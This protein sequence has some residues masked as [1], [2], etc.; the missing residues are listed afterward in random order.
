MT[1]NSNYLSNSAQPISSS[2]K[3]KIFKLSPAYIFIAPAVIYI[4]ALV[5]F[6]TLRVAILSVMETVR[7]TG[8]THFVGLKNFQKVLS[9][10]VFQKS[11]VQTAQWVIFTA[12]GHF[13]LGFILA[14]AM[15][16]KLI[17]RTITSTCRAL[18]LLPWALTSVVVAI[19][20]QL[21]A[22]PMISPIAKVLKIL[23]STTDFVPLAYPNTAMW[24]LIAVQI[25]QFTP[26]F[27]LMLLA[28]L[29]TLDPML[30][31]AAKVDGASWWQEILHVTLP[32]FK[33]A[34]AHTCPF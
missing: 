12:I 10:P 28:G 8:E 24:F 22:H 6:P 3:K 29:Q 19:L 17:P 11:A 27:M 14:L 13:V 4:V 18:I 20:T 34:N 1:N 15:N 31:D 5:F 25:W 21:W 2:S 7:K 23:G 9:D 30:L 16:S 32:P 33:R 26:F